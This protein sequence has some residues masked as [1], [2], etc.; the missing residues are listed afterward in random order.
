M[1]QT[2]YTIVTQNGKTKVYTTEK[3]LLLRR[4]KFIGTILAAVAVTLLM[5]GMSLN[6]SS[7]TMPLEVVFLVGMGI[8]AVAL[9]I[10]SYISDSGREEKQDKRNG[11]KR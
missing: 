11:K 7:P 4:L 6:D 8:F 10:C 1:K 9:L 5:C 2:V 3:Y